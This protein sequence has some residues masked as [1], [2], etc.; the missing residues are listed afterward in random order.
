MIRVT[1]N[2]QGGCLERENEAEILE[3]E[4]QVVFVMRVVFRWGNK[5]RKTLVWKWSDGFQQG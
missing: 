4:G 1:K 2:E 5:V 3:R